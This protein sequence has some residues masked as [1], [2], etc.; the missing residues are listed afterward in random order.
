[1]E[2]LTTEKYNNGKYPKNGLNGHEFSEWKE[3]FPQNK[4]D[5]T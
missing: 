3:V 5:E 4:D 1:M 2:T